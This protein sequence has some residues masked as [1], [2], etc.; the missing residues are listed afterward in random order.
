VG[1]VI[2]AINNKAAGTPLQD[3]VRKL[4]AGEPGFAELLKG[5]Q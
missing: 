2:E 1:K 4:I 5:N 3:V